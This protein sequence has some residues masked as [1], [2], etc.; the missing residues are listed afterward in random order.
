M[1]LLGISA[2]Q[3]APR[4]TALSLAIAGIVLAPLQGAGAAPATGPD[5]SPLDPAAEAAVEV[6]DEVVETIEEATDTA[7]PQTFG[8]QADEPGEAPDLTTQ[9]ASLTEVYDDLPVAERSRAARLL[10][11]PTDSGSGGLLVY[12]SGATV[13]QDCNTR[14][15]VHWVEGNKAGKHKSTA[16]WARTVRNQVDSVWQTEVTSMGYK[17]PQSDGNK[18]NPSGTT[19][20]RLD[21][22]LGEI[23]NNGYYGY[24][25]Q[26][27]GASGPYLVLDNDY[28]NV[29][30]PSLNSLKVTAAHEFFHAVQF[31]Y[32]LRADAWLMETT[33]TWM[34]ERV[35]DDIN[36]NRQYL[37]YS[38][39]RRPGVPLDKGF[40]YFYGN[41]IFFEHLSQTHG[42]VI[43]RDIWQRVGNGK[44]ATTAINKALKKRGTNLKKT[45]TRFAADNAAP[46]MA[47]SEGSAYPKAKPAKKAKLGKKKRTTAWQTS[48]V[49][50]LSS[51]TV[52]YV[53]QGD[54]GK[55]WKLRV[56]VKGPQRV[57]GMMLVKRAG[58]KWARKQVV[59]KK[60]TGGKAVAFNT[61]KVKWVSFTVANTSVKA[62][63]NKTKVQVRGVL[64][65]K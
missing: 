20:Y 36:D 6:L 43:V 52:R 16:A 5:D 58:G 3:G 21:V 64:K 51:T 65:K 59:I 39:L 22:Y 49:K 26:E 56:Q 14:I 45:F 57:R 17:S 31:G 30:G 2:L 46:G 27:A 54:L 24:A 28:S 19:G 13:K 32:N 40:P 62:K 61:N 11:R 4:R 35:H 42:D 33:A 50:H 47:Y 10:A 12:P 37:A 9:L 55:K 8:P 63:H 25:T 7:S 15:C 29:P 1:R 53:P 44:K 34:E 60:G 23:S 48:T 18:G 41:W 38:A